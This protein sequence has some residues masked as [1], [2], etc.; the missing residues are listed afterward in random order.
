M[1]L[2]LTPQHFSVPFGSQHSVYV[3]LLEL[4]SFDTVLYLG[5]QSGKAIP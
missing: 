5:T 3:T 4:W 1:N 2:Y